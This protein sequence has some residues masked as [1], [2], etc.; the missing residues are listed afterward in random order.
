MSIPRGEDAPTE[1]Q[2]RTV[3]DVLATIAGV[4]AGAVIFYV[5]YLYYVVGR[6][7]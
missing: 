4:V 3:S 7:G 2:D 6:G 5:L 1:E